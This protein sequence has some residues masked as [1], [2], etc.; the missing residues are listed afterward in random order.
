MVTY[1]YNKYVVFLKEEG[2]GWTKRKEKLRGQLIIKDWD[3]LFVSKRKRKRKRNLFFFE[4]EN[5]KERKWF[6]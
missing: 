1:M 2:R 5:A 4:E 6:V 3:D